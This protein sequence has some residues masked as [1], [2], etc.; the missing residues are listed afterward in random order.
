MDTTSPSYPPHA[1]GA[2]GEAVAVEL[3]ERDG[4]TIRERGYRLGRRE[5]DVIAER[6][7]IVAFVEVKTRSGEGFGAPAEAVTWR[8]RREIETV[9]RD[10]LVR[11]VRGE[12][13]VRFDIVSIV[14]GPERR[15]IRCDHIADA[16]RPDGWTP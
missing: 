16:W 13:G 7:R 11:H 2:W 3:L 10:Y 4:W 12:Y 15:V 9:A 1:L 5:V 14:A 8:K 6:D